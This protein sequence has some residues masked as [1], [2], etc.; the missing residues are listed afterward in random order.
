MKAIKN[1]HLRLEDRIAIETYLACGMT[2][3]EVARRIGKD[4]T[5]V[6]KEV[7]KARYHVGHG[8]KEC[9]KLS[10]A[11]FVCNGCERRQFCQ[12]RK[13]VYTGSVAHN[14]YAR[15][16]RASRSHL[17]IT[18]DEIE[19]INAIVA[20]LMIEKHHSVNQVYINH[21]GELP[22]C[23]STFYRYIDCGV[24]AVRNID[25]AR[26]VR[27]KVKKEYDHSRSVRNP[28]V[29]VGRFYSDFSDWAEKNPQ[30]D[31]V[32]MDTVIGTMGGKGGKCMLTLFWRK[33]NLMKIVL[34]PYKKVECVTEAFVAIRGALGDGFKAAF[35]AILTDNGTEFDDPDSIEISHLTGEK[36]TSVF[37]CDPNCSWQKGGIERNHEFIRY[38]LP[39]GTSF[40]GLTQG[41]CDKIANHINSTPR[42]SL[43]GFTPYEAG[44]M[45]LGKEKMDKL[46]FQPVARDEVN[47]SIKLIK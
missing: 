30:S 35:P 9:A 15:T 25:L 37:Y 22:F 11:P 13:F 43:N 44:L 18:K 40:A 2:V 24:I 14:E 32:E 3:T 41:D 26:K 19:G 12:L 45:S 6:A 33:S 27:Y 39:K 47:L 16:L 28:K 38:I 31:V 36:E 7:K 8:T 5:T 21:P 20:P 29:R 34:L 10:K 42:V 4:R 17:R 1:K 46:G 23:K